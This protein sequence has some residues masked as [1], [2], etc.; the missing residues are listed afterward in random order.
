M[1]PNKRMHM[2]LAKRKYRPTMKGLLLKKMFKVLGIE[3]VSDPAERIM[4]TKRKWQMQLATDAEQVA[5]EEV[6]PFA[7]FQMTPKSLHLLQTK[8]K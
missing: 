7:R 2:L 5:L 4:L 3:D 6:E 8:G 1:T